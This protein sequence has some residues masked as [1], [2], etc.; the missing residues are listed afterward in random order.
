MADTTDKRSTATPAARSGTRR[1]EGP[2]REQ[3]NV[4]NAYYENPNAAQVARDLGVSERNVRRIRDSFQEQLQERWD[5]R[6]TEEQAQADVRRRR[7]DDWIDGG[8]DRAMQELDAL[9]ESQNESIRLRVARQRIEWALRAANRG[10]A[11]DVFTVLDELASAHARDL[12]ERLDAD[13]P[14]DEQEGDAA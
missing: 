5:R 9:L 14:A 6:D 10:V 13:P 12:R 3:Q 1:K 8:L 7:V 11:A 4:L 2:T